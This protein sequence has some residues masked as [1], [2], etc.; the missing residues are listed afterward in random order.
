MAN[1]SLGRAHAP[2]ATPLDPD[3]IEALIPTTVFTQAELNEWE[4]TNILEGVAWA[5]SRRARNSLDAES[6]KELHFRMFSRTW[7]WAGTFRRSNKNIGGEWS[8]VPTALR[9]L[10][11]DVRHWIAHSTC[12]ADEIGAR[13]HHRLVQIHPFPNGNG[14]FAR[15]ATD[16]LLEREL[17]VR[18]FTWGSGRLDD[19]SATRAQYIAAL[20]SADHHDMV[21]LL[22]FVRS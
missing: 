14:R 7:A 19:A 15:L 20:R 18:A 17:G 9:E 21:P 3:E 5:Q 1:E 4:Q 10:S 11:D 22:K 6:L 8:L 2:G 16:V 12:E 13:F